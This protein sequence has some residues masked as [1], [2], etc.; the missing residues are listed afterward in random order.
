MHALAGGQQA[1]DAVFRIHTNSVNSS[2]L[3]IACNTSLMA[4][5]QLAG[6]D[7]HATLVAIVDDIIT[8]I[9]TLASLVKEKVDEI[10]ENLQKPSNYLVNKKKQPY[11]YTINAAAHE[12]VVSAAAFK[13]QSDIHWVAA[14]D[15]H[16]YLFKT[17]SI[18][19]FVLVVI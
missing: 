2:K 4:G 11:V 18:L 19:F 10:R 5:L 9:G 8:I 3:F 1:T 16:I 6:G 17:Q 7:H 12:A 14:W 15:L 13:L